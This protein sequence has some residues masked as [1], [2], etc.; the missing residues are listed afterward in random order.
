MH[1]MVNLLL[2]EERNLTVYLTKS[3]LNYTNKLEYQ[4][5]NA[6]I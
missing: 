5:Y 1:K 3:K 4:K 6:P 2:G